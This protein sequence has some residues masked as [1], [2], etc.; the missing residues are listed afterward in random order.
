MADTDHIIMFHGTTDRFLGSIKQNGLIPTPELRPSHFESEQDGMMAAFDGTYL[1][2]D[3]NTSQWHAISAAKKF[4]GN[5]LMFVLRV[6]VSD[7][8]P[9]E[10]EINCMLNYPIFQALE[11]DD[12]CD[13]DELDLSNCQP[14]TLEVAEQAA[15]RL[16]SEAVD[17]DAQEI[18]GGCLFRMIDHALGDDWDKNPFYFHPETQV[19]WNCPTWMVKLYETDE[20]RLIYRKEMD[21]LTQAL[22][23]LSPFE[24]PCK[25]DSCRG[26]ILSPMVLEGPHGMPSF[27]GYG[28]IDAPFSIFD[29]SELC[30]GNEIR[31]PDPVLDA[32]MKELGKS[33]AFA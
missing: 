18:I 15:R 2:S 25:L 19:G 6:P 32:T 21:T 9:D 27:I 28:P 22:K 24:Y 7:L 10:D 5:P 13:P 8:V 12:N 29:R 17:I 11:G 20:G 3:R 33:P 31:L 23:G 4:G 1:A 14:F 16:W 26:R 30:T